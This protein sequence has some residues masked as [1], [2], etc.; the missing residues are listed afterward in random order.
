MGHSSFRSNLLR[1]PIRI[2]TVV[3][4]RRVA[5]EKI[6][7]D[8]DYTGP[9]LTIVGIL[10]STSLY[11]QVVSLKVVFKGPDAPLLN[12]QFQDSLL[13][14]VF[15]SD[16]ATVAGWI[17]MGLLLYFITGRKN[18]ED[19]FKA[20]L[21]IYGYS[22]VL[23]L[24]IAAVRILAVGFFVPTIVVDTSLPPQVLD[25][26]VTRWQALFWSGPSVPMGLVLYLVNFFLTAVW[27]ATGVNFATN[28]KAGET[29]FYAVLL[30][31]VLGFVSQMLA[32]GSV[33]Y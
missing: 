23:G 4:N 32:L 10:V 24:P 12:N 11:V 30:F 6:A 27:Y 7:R 3:A 14:F 26:Q 9:I 20:S 28:G 19:G 25:Q 22:L 17:T 2:I 21:S 15:L 13:N 1:A 8:P 31:D 18:W 33:R 16:L 29:A 5:F